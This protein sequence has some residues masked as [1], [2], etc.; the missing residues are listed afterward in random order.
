MHAYTVKLRKLK[1]TC[2]QLGFSVRICTKA[3]S[4]LL[5]RITCCLSLFFCSKLLNFERE[6]DVIR[7]QIDG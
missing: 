1:P 7:L 3:V 4:S 6:E 5:D 2:A